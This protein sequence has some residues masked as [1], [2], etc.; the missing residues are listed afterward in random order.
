MHRFV[1]HANVDHYLDLLNGDLAPSDRRTITRLLVMEEDKLVGD[2]QHLEFA[3]RRAASGHERVNELRSLRDG[4]A[5]GTPERAQA[6]SLL[7]VYENSQ[8]LLEDFCRR[9][10]EMINRGGI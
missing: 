8:T 3:E 10:R 6:D 2:L 5:F 4:F 7:I 1:A 9:M